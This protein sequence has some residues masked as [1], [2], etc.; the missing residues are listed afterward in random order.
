MPKW[1]TRILV[2]VGME[3]GGGGGGLQC[4]WLCVKYP[5]SLSVR[6]QEN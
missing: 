5:A 6:H 3:G 1:V 4:V 2:E